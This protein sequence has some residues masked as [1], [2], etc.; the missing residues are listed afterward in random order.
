MS[1]DYKIKPIKGNQEKGIF[2]RDDWVA[3]GDNHFIS[4]NILREL[5]NAEDISAILQSK[6][7]NHAGKVSKLKKHEACLKSSVLLMCYSIELYCKAGLIRIFQNIPRSD[8]SRMIKKE[9]GHDITA[10]YSLIFDD[11][12]ENK[13]LLDKIKPL[14]L[15][16]ARYPV[17]P[18]SNDH[19]YEEWN[20]ISSEIYSD[21]FY[22]ELK[23]LSEQ[24][25]TAILKI[26]S[27]N[28]NPAY[29]V[30]YKIDEDGYCAIRTG[31]N[32]RPYMVVK[33]S[34]EQ[35]KS[36]ADNL[37]SLIEAFKN[38]KLNSI[39]KNLILNN[40][41]HELRVYEK[42]EKKCKKSV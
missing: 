5:S 42:M 41:F 23:N 40:K 27:D 13:I 16:E 28:K 25:K 15:Y 26:D 3:E 24:I 22:E 6:L 36:G 1:N 7:I 34:A 14:I 11:T 9:Y 37:E 35:I 38:S 21:K 10:M 4:A 20:K 32:L 8:F 29:F 30:T 19:Y 39:R 17:D 12:S 31:G 18:K 33:Y 2:N